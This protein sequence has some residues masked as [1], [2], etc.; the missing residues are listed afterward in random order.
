VLGALPLAARRS[1]SPAR[2]RLVFTRT[3]RVNKATS[4]RE[5]VLVSTKRLSLTRRRRRRS[6]AVASAD[7]TERP[8]EARSS[9]NGTSEAELH[10]RSVV[11]KAAVGRQSAEELSIEA[12]TRPCDARSRRR[13]RAPAPGS[14]FAG[15]GRAEAG[16]SPSSEAPPVD[17]SV[18]V[19][20]RAQARVG[21]TIGGLSRAGWLRGRKAVRQEGSEI[22]NRAA[23]RVL[24]S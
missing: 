15:C 19:S 24:V 18:D 16:G 13:S 21:R 6:P 17:S 22:G 20:A 2:V 23:Y 8:G 4:S 11:D 12:P 3:R 14:G 1:S 10:A 5:G 9:W 7:P